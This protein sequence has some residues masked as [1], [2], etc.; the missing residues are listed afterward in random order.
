[1]IRRVIIFVMLVAGLG[2]G[3]QKRPF[4]FEDMMALKRVGEPVVSPDGKWVAF[5]AVEVN[6]EQNKKTPHL[7]VVPLNPPFAGAKDGAPEAKQISSDAAGEDRPR[8]SPDGK[9]LAFI[10]AKDGGAQVWV[11]DFDPAAVALGT[12]QKITS[13]ST[14]AGGELWSPDGKYI[15]FTS[16]V[17]PDCPDDA[18][19]KRATSRRRSRR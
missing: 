6:L 5:S 10:S 16:D 17:Y 4:T 18:C 12:P 3:Q 1:M 8:W 11:A 2:W 9:R 7:W 14:E 19:N 15:L 13:I